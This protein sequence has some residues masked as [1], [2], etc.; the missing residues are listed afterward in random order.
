MKLKKYSFIALVLVT[1]LTMSCGGGAEMGDANPTESNDSALTEDVVVSEEDS[2]E[3]EF[4][5][6]SALQISS[7]FR[8]SG[9]VF[10]DGI[11]NNPANTAN[12]YSKFE[13][14]L[15]F[16]A[17]SADLFY[18][19]LNDQSQ[20]SIQYLKSIRQ[21]A[22][23]TGL[24]GIF[25]AG[26]IFERF[27]KNIGKQDSVINI[28]LE[29]QEKTDMLIAE[30][31]EEHTAMIIFTGA[32]VEGM[33]IGL[34]A[35]RASENEMLRERL[36][37]QMTILPNLIKGLEIQPNKNAETEGLQKKLVEVQTY[38]DSIEGLKGDDEYSYDISVMSTSH[39]VKLYDLMAGIR[40]GITK[41]GI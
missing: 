34:D 3:P 21:L 33:Y 20:L 7:I 10:V 22:D 35:A 17:Y 13:K 40:K 4:I 2:D 5:I 29:F 6:P 8:S 25:N 27:E 1:G 28:M 15:N 23:E 32:W 24:S 26:P 12:Y 36:V 30:Q 41:Q 31:N 14:L 38:F 37:E 16:G 11:C 39:F 19:V 18:C 9:L